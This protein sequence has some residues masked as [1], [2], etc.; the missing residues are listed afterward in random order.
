MSLGRCWHQQYLKCHCERAVVAECNDADPAAP[1]ADAACCC[2]CCCCCCSCCRSQQSTACMRQLLMGAEIQQAA[3]AAPGRFPCCKNL[4]AA[5]TFILS[6]PWLQWGSCAQRVV[7]ML[8]LDT[9]AAAA[10]AA[11][12]DCVCCTITVCQPMR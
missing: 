10:A 9:A 2:C 7:P 8:A 1:A 5:R 12:A 11:A 6:E 4:S 3:R